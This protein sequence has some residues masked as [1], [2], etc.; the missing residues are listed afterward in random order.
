MRS[1]VVQILLVCVLSVL[2]FPPALLA[3]VADKSDP[4]LFSMTLQMLAALMLVLG[5]FLLLYA[6]VRKSRSWIPGKADGQQIEVRA[7]RH[8][9]PKKAL[10]LVDVDGRRFFLSTAGEQIRLLSGWNAR[11]SAPASGSEPK[12]DIQSDFATLMHQEM[13]D[14]VADCD[15]PAVKESGC[16]RV[17]KH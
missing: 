9:G 17:Q 2:V 10:Y 8:L 11:D 12:S 4:S 6:L 7:V 1:A 14:A 5:L 16:E 3:A 15:G 13:T